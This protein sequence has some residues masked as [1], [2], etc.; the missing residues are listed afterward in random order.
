MSRKTDNIF[1]IVLFFGVL[2][3]FVRLFQHTIW[4]DECFTVNLVHENI[5]GIIEGSIK[6]VHPPLSFLL[7]KLFCAIFGYSIPVFKFASLF[8]VIILAAVGYKWLAYH[9]DKN[10]GLIFA[11]MVFFMPTSFYNTEIRMYSLALFFITA[12][13]F[14]II[15]GVVYDNHKWIIISAVPAILAA[16]THYFALITTAIIYAYYFLYILIKKR[17]CLKNIII[18]IL[19][20]F[21]FYGPWIIVVINQ[22]TNENAYSMGSNSLIYYLKPMIS[23]VCMFFGTIRNHSEIN[24]IALA[25]TGLLIVFIMSAL[26]AYVIQNKKSSDPKIKNYMS[27][28]F[29]TIVVFILLYIV[30]CL[31]DI[32]SHKFVARYLYMTVGMLYILISIALSFCLE[33]KIFK[34][35]V[36]LALVIVLFDFGST[37]YNEFKSDHEHDATIKYL[38]T[39]VGKDDVIITDSR[40]DNWIVYDYYLKDVNYELGIDIDSINELADNSTGDIF[41]IHNDLDGNIADPGDGWKYVMASELAE[42]DI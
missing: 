11:F 10:S 9:F 27:I 33:Q 39:E 32:M 5:S 24:I 23:F 18:S 41:F 4:A 8:P 17:E 13:L 26:L 20:C 42:N 15:E 31:M 7:D 21:V 29:M 22:A 36:I 12:F 14:A 25:L 3:N 30:G 16:Y 28:L 19:I 34:Q 40:I 6:D 2:A 35:V 1:N 37:V 38:E